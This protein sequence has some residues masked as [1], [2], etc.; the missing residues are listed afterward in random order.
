MLRLELGSG[1]PLFTNSREDP[2]S[3]TGERKKV[4]GLLDPGGG[5]ECVAASGPLPVNFRRFFCG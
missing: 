2:L 1:L 3:E 4:P 5:E